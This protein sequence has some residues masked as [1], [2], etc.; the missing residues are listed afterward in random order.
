M[1]S[2]PPGWTT[3]CED[4]LRQPRSAAGH[5]GSTIAVNM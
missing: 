1:I 5:A 4:L 2:A 3:L